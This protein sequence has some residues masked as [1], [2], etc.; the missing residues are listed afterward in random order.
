MVSR[1][2]LSLRKAADL[3]QRNWSI[4]EPTAAD[5]N[6]QSMKFFR[7]RNGTGERQGDIP[8]ERDDVPLGRLEAASFDSYPER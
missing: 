1:I 4:A 7:P 2:V 8:V 3:Q 6:L 5:M